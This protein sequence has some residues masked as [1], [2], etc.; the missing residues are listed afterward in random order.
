[1]VVTTWY[2]SVSPRPQ[3]DGDLIVEPHPSLA[4]ASGEHHGSLDH[5]L[6]EPDAALIAVFLLLGG[7]VLKFSLRS[8]KARASFTASRSWGR[9]WMRR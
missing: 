4:P 3:K 7:L 2:T 9:S 5:V 1:M 6:Q 8:P